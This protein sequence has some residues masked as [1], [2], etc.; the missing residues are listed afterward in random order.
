MPQARTRRHQAHRSVEIS[1]WSPAYRPHP[2]QVGLQQ[3]FVVAGEEILRGD[4][5]FADLV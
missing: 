5:A 1:R 3:V 2:N 4:H